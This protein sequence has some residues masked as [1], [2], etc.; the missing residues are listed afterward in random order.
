MIAYH[1][2]PDLKAKFLEQIALHEAADRIQHTGYANFK[3]NGERRFTG[4]CAV[5]CSLESLRVI[6]GLK[7]IV[8][9]D[10]TLYERY[11]GVPQA[12][13]RLEDRL[14]EN[15]TVKDSLT[16]PRRFAEA[17]PIGA[18]V[19]MVMPRFLLDLLT[20]PDGGVQRRCAKHEKIAAVVKGVSDLYRQWVEMGTKP[21]AT[22]W[23][24]ARADAAAAAAAADAS[25]A[26]SADAA[27]AYAAASADAAA[28]YAA[29]YAA[30]AA[31]AA[32]A[33]VDAAAYAAAGQSARTAEY[34]RQA[35]VLLKLLAAEGVTA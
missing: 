31:S 34:D 17:I 10:H 7:T 11:L 2:Q 33:A 13:A 9:S 21:S 35:A 3:M 28:A 22:Q 14:F 16:W 26:A 6:E 18:D 32:D 8:H 29:A 4:G 23:R 24:E 20:A 15:I 30:D 25:A 12:L 1:G 5:G 19:A 27:A